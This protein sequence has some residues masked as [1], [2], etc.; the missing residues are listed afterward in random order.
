M[1]LIYFHT[2]GGDMNNG[3]NK[4]IFAQSSELNKS[5]IDFSLVLL[6][7]INNNYPHHDFIHYVSLKECSF[8]KSMIFTRFCRQYFAKKYI[9][10][11]LKFS[12]SE[13]VLYV[14]YPLPIFLLPH[15]LSTDRKCKI[16]LECNSIEINEQKKARSY[17]PYSKELFFGQEFRKR[18]DAII[19][20]TDQITRYQIARL[21]S[22]NKPHMTIGNGF[23]VDSVRM[24]RPP[25]YPGSTLNI[26][27][28]SNI[29]SWH[30]L[31]RLIQGMADYKGPIK[32]TI[33]I[34]GDGPEVPHLKKLIDSLKINDRIVFHGFTTGKDLDPL[35]DQCH[36]A[37]GSLGLHR[38]GL[39][40]ASIL[41]AREY[42][43]RGIPYITACN[44]PDFPDDFSFLLKVP[45]EDSAI[46]MEKVLAFTNRVFEIPDHPQKMR[47][48]AKENLDWSV[49][50]KKLKGF[51]EELVKE[52]RSN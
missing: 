17:F 8:F 37:I 9:K 46:D 13:T 42:C 43:S 7:G 23:E 29:S 14:R 5:G 20:V 10:K 11:V 33:H 2:Y 18:C 22:F 24:R 27:S 50:M 45:S 12:G 19:G 41:K 4:K 15:D 32:I 34:V 3:V 47:H 26:I 1:Q 49:K 40:E 44:D 38:I 31:D 16:V 30:G 28:V 25:S 39:Q 21:G 48:Y 6:G 51:L 52:D 36:I 35:F